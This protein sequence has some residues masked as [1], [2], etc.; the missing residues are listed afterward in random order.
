MSSTPVRS[1][2]VPQRS[3]PGRPGPDLEVHHHELRR[4]RLTDVSDLLGHPDQSLVEAD[5]RLHAGHEQIQGVR[6]SCR[7]FRAP[8]PTPWSTYQLG[9]SHPSR[10]AR[11]PRP[12]WRQADVQ[13]ERPPRGWRQTSP[14]ARTTRAP[15][16]IRGASGF[17]NPAWTSLLLQPSRS[18]FPRLT[19]SSPSRRQRPEASACWTGD[20]AG[21]PSRTGSDRGFEAARARGQR[22]CPGRGQIEQGDHHESHGQAGQDPHHNRHHRRHPQYR[23]STILR[24]QRN[25]IS[26][27]SRRRRACH[28]H[29]FVEER[30][31]VARV[32]D[33][34]A[35]PTRMGS[36]AR[37]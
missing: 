33:R 23:M 11:P 5:A 31:H 30:L 14:A 29:E 26:C 22:P 18:R 27:R 20:A 15:K 35:R 4:K 16:K 25:P 12:A 1:A 2:E 34:D 32:D 37:V 24:I 13:K 19:I 3:V 9:A 21:T 17:Q 10:P 8:R 6:Q 28:A 36:A 7:D